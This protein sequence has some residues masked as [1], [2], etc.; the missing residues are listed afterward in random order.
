[1]RRTR[2]TAAAGITAC[3]ALAGPALAADGDGGST[4]ISATVAAVGGERSVTSVAP[5]ALASTGGSTILTGAVGVVVTETSRSG[6]NPWSVTA[7][8]TGLTSGSSTIP[9]SAMSLADRTVV[10][11]AGGG[12]AAGVAGTGT[13]DSPQTLFTVSGQLPGSVYTGTYT[14]AA[15]MS[16]TPPNGT[17]TGAYTGTLTVTLVQ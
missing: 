4:T 12:T 7:S 11:V 13:L 17:V 3:L 2:L 6:T 16:L 15:T 5:V 8:T 1:M 10:Q 9:A 14:G